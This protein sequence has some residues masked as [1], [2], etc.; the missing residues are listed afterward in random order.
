MR[1]RRPSCSEARNRW[2]P[3]VA[4]SVSPSQTGLAGSG[5]IYLSSLCTC[6]CV[7]FPCLASTAGGGRD[8]ST[9]QRV[10]VFSRNRQTLV[11]HRSRWCSE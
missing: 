2:S 7:V 5:L 9:M 11:H 1:Q 8:G 6:M 3:L 4:H 10:N